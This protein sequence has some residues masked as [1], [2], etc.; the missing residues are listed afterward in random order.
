MADELKD[1]EKDAI[2]KAVQRLML[3]SAKRYFRMLKSL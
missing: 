3:K 2:M 1:F